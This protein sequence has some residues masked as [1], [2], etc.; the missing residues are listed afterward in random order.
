MKANP[1]HIAEAY[2]LYMYLHLKSIRKELT[3]AEKTRKGIAYKKI[4][5][6]YEYRA[7]KIIVRGEYD[8]REITNTMIEEATKRRERKEFLNDKH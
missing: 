2:H 4:I 8:S 7:T 5:N 1:P 6:Y 3:H